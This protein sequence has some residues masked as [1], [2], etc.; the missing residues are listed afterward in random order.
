MVLDVDHDVE[1]GIVIGNQ[2]QHGVATGPGER[3]PE[4][5]GDRGRRSEAPEDERRRL[6]H[7]S[8]NL[9]VGIHGRGQPRRGR[10]V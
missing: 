7:R 3:G 5:V 6:Q 1:A 9:P 2:V 10:S 4:G 8:N